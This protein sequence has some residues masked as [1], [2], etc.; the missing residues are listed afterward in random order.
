[1]QS[2]RCIFLLQQS[3][4]ESELLELLRVLTVLKCLCKENAGKT[5]GNKADID[6]DAVEAH[7]CVDIVTNFTNE[8]YTTINGLLHSL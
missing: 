4:S 2:I 8:Q 3:A 6:I 5:L 1:M 7:C